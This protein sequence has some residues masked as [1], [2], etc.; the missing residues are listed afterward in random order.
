MLMLPPFSLHSPSRTKFWVTLCVSDVSDVHWQW[1]HLQCHCMETFWELNFLHA[2]AERCLH[3]ADVG[4]YLGAACAWPRACVSAPLP[5][6]VRA[7]C[8]YEAPAGPIAPSCWARARDPVLWALRVLSTGSLLLSQEANSER[9][10]LPLLFLMQ[11]LA[12]LHAHHVIHRDIKGQNVLL[13]E[14]AEVK[15]GK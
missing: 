9:P 7:V 3:S 2:I 8:C 11:G 15:L 6:A 14:N 1:C 4:L 5:K 10:L 13:T 12:H